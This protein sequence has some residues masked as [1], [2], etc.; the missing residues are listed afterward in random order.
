MIGLREKEKTVLV[1]KP[2]ALQVVTQGE[3]PA[4][5][6]A[7][8]TILKDND[9]DV[10]IRKSVCLTGVEGKPYDCEEGG[11]VDVCLLEH[12]DNDT[13]AKVLAC[14][15]LKAHPV[16]CSKTKWDALRDAEFFF[17]CLEGQSVERTLAVIKPKV[18]QDVHSYVVNSL[19]QSGLLIVAQKTC[20]FTKEQAEEMYHDR[21]NKDELVTYLTSGPSLCCV[22]EGPGAVDRCRLMCGPSRKAEYAN[23]ATIRGNF[24]TDDVKN[25][26]HCATSVSNAKK[27]ISL[28]FPTGLLSGMERT[29]CLVKPEAVPELQAIKNS[30]K[31]AGFQITKEQSLVMTDVRAEQFLKQ[32]S[33]LSSSRLKANIRHLTSGTLVALVLTRVGAVGV[34]KQVLGPEIPKEAAAL[35]SKLLRAKYG[36]DALRNA[37]Y[38]SDT[39]KIAAVDVGFLFPDLGVFGIPSESKVT[40]YFYRKTALAQMTLPEVGNSVLLDTT[41]QQFLSEGLLELT[42][43]RHSGADAITFLAKYLK[44]NNPNRPKEIKQEVVYASGEETKM[45]Y[46]TVGAG[47]TLE[48]ETFSVELPQKPKYDVLEIDT[49]DEEVASKKVSGAEF[50]H[51]PLVVFVCGGPGSGKGTN[52]ARL[53]EDFNY[54]HLSAGDLLRAEVAAKTKRGMELET[55]MLEGKL[56]PDEITIEL[57]KN[58]M[59]ANQTKNGFLVDGF[60]RS[61]EQAIKFE[62]DVAECQMVLNFECSDSVMTERIMERGKTSGRVDD[63]EEAIKKRLDTFYSQTKPVVDYYKHMGRLRSVNADGDIDSVYA[64][65]KKIFLSKFVYLVGTCGMRIPESLEAMADSHYAHIDASAIYEKFVREAPPGKALEV[66]QVKAAL[67]DRK[68]DLAPSLSCPLIVSAVKEKQLKGYTAFLFTDFPRTEKQ[69]AFLEDRILCES[70]AIVLEYPRL[71]S[72]ELGISAGLTQ[73]QAE[74]DD[75]VVNGEETVGMLAAVGDVTKIPCELPRVAKA[76]L[77]R[78][79]KLQTTKVI[80]KALRPKMTICLGPPGCHQRSFCA[81]WAGRVSGATPVD[82]DE[83]LDKELERETETGVVMHNMLSKG[84][85]IPLSITFRLLSNLA[86]FGCN[87][88]VV[89]N[90]PTNAD[91]IKYLTEEFAV[92]EVFS[93]M[94]EGEDANAYWCQMFLEKKQ[95]EGSHALMD[96][97]IMFSDRME[98]LTAVHNEFSASG[99]VQLYPLSITKETT[100]EQVMDLALAALK[101]KYILLTG[102][103]ASGVSTVGEELAKKYGTVVRCSPATLNIPTTGGEGALSGADLCTALSSFFHANA[104][105]GVTFALEG[106]PM[107]SEQALAMIENFGPPKA[108]YYFKGTKDVIFARAEAANAALEE[109]AAL[110]AETFGADFE[111]QEPLLDGIVDCLKE[112][113]LYTTLDADV[114]PATHV[115]TCATTLAKQCVLVLAPSGKGL[116][117]MVGTALANKIPDVKLVDVAALISSASSVLSTD[118]LATFAAELHRVQT[119]M[120]V[121]SAALVA[122]LL[123]ACATKNSHCSCFILTNYF[124][125]YTAGSYPTVRDLVDT[126]SEALSLS[127]VVY[128]KFANPDG[129]PMA[130]ALSRLSEP[131]DLSGA[132]EAMEFLK[133]VVPAE[134][135]VEFTPDMSVDFEPYHF[136]NRVGRTVAEA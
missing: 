20:T 100:A 108:A 103:P 114:E 58:A 117:Q 72:I 73:V 67:A 47:E 134:K 9:F 13:V 104:K 36:R 49:R 109:P 55:I 76:D 65:A 125:S 41:L 98:N 131:E 80:K 101:A 4:S 11:L 122:E 105:A 21:P 61:V 42:R 46:V 99:D 30:L 5:V 120:S 96:Y 74:N 83:M 16:Y 118:S 25:V 136:A 132:A 37:F 10:K 75:A 93:L 116:S 26:I 50:D 40:D 56:V 129:T 33:S 121:P 57:M 45:E 107:N 66:E 123:S 19:L 81:E 39:T 135:V 34:L 126:L 70:C 22:L 52:C 113:S 92:E 95:S 115:A 110:D 48:G 119:G 88:L 3:K 6:A 111:A 7:I 43:M 130:E 64:A 86:R 54:C 82:V 79:L 63:N 14:E 24:G 51:T 112:H 78:Q 8:E 38:A 27:E 15:A 127:K 44:D 71:D 89:E 106:F 32:N 124:A 31:A 77:V 90:F 97:E 18:G 85:V 17:P 29:L 2:A 59:L 94:P 1:I 69:R 91:E 28:V 35:S 12:L 62:K 87:R 68:L 23:T 128:C 53:A 133:T 60:P 102:V 84:Q